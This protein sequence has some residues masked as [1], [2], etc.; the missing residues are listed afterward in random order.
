MDR[1]AEALVFSKT[2]SGN[3]TMDD[4]RIQQFKQMAEADPTNELGHFSL[5]KAYMDAG[6]FAAAIAPLTRALSINPR[7]SKAYH[8]LAQNYEKTGD[9]AKAVT[10]ATT[11][12][13]EADKLG[14]RMPRDAMAALL[15]EWNAPVP[16]FKTTDSA[17]PSAPGASS[18]GFK[19]SRCGRPEGKLA[20]PPFKGKVGDQIYAN[21]CTPCWREWIGMGTKVINELGLQLAT[22]AGQDAYDQYMLEFLQLEPT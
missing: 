22:K 17:A 19:C 20:K 13:V 21:I 3:T 4:R 7:L 12:V 10:T 15:K 16:A 1:A 5:G 11:G 6:D 14:D 8:L 18:D 2:R 9:R